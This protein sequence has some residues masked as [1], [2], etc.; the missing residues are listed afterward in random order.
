MKMHTTVNEI[1]FMKCIHV[2]SGLFENPLK[3]LT[4]G[5][6]IIMLNWKMIP[7]V[8][9]ALKY[10]CS[11][12]MLNLIRQNKTRKPNLEFHVWGR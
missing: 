8:L 11:E 4:F 10:L 1:E 6:K 7:N 5:A 12:Q 2:I 3:V 9:D